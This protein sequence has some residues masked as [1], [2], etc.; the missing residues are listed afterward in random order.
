MHGADRALGSTAV[1][2]FSGALGASRKSALS[3]QELRTARLLLDPELASGALSPDALRSALLRPALRR[4]VRTRSVGLPPVRLVEQV[5]YKV[6]RLRFEQGATDPQRAVRRA[7]RGAAAGE[8]TRG[9]AAGEPTRGAAAGE[10]TRGAAAGEDAGSGEGAA[11]VG[12]PRIL[13]RVD[14]FPHYQA[15]DQPRR[16]GSE[17]FARFHGI[18]A[19]AGVRYLLAV[20]PR[21][22]RDPLAPGAGDSRR[23]TEDEAVLLGRLA[24]EGVSFAMHGRDHRS[25]FDSPR[26]RSELCGLGREQTDGLI[27]AGLAELA[28]HGIAANVF[29]PP[30]NRF[31]A[32]QL[33]WL[34]NRFAVVCGGPESIGKLGFQPTPQWRGETVYLPSYAPFYGTAGEILRALP[35]VE[36]AGVSWLP[37]VLHWGWEADAG[38]R[39]LEALAERIAAYA[40]PWE[41][42]LAA[43]ERSRG[44][45]P[46]A[47]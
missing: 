44:A 24:G 25:R 15:W 18:L 26:R 19:G 33:P 47:R 40:A 38:W 16:F 8:P 29:V 46:G 22:S 41:D 27:E 21:V 3:Q 4:A 12:G 42:F 10:P 20:S 45:P 37:L 17:G 36:A 34:A 39:E 31:D 35:W 23:L 43:V 7:T 13:L 9:A 30:F 5:L 6:G 1:R 11:D 28:Q 2:T 32:R 14:E